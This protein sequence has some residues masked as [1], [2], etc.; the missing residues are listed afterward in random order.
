MKAYLFVI[1]VFFGSLGFIKLMEIRNEDPEVGVPI[2]LVLGISY[3]I[4]A[5]I[6]FRDKR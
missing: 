5:L 6:G 2:I 1:A 3:V 4:A